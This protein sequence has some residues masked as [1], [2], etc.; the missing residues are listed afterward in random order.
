VTGVREPVVA[1]SFYPGSADLLASTVDEL[2]ASA[3][4]R[5]PAIEPGAL[6]G[7]IVPHAG[8][9]YSGPVAA[10]G[11]AL[12]RPSATPAVV[13]ILGPSHFES[14]TGM[15]V[16]PHDA[17]RTPLGE[18]PLDRALRRAI[19]DAGATSDDLPHRAE[20]SI[21]VQLPFL[22]RCLPGVP[23]LPVAVGRGSPHAKAE[24]LDQVLPLDALL[25]V[26][27]DLSHYH[28]AATASE[29]DE[30]T[31]AS[32]EAGAVDDLRDADACGVDALRL[33]LAWALRRGD[34]LQRLDL[35]NSADTA[36]DPSRV[37][38]Y[39]AFA[40]IELDDDASPVTAAAPGRSTRSY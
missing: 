12:L 30:R 29:L 22:Q 16:A 10:S 28:D 40:I 20:H 23:I 1:G 31:A 32:I 18:V 39:G 35:R 13:V 5:G 14:L 27:T 6:R 36:G 2:L 26:S 34:A 15:A 8:Y 25:V 11:Y 38:G 3:T 4:V 19:V 9:V 37:V 33:A 24:L 17:W 21:E 7:L